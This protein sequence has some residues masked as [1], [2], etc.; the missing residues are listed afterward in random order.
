MRT[1]AVA[2]IAVHR[3]EGG[4]REFLVVLRSSARHGYWHLV[5]GG[6][7]EGET[8]AE[9]AC[10]ELEEETGLVG[11]LSFEPLPVSLSY[12]DGTDR[13]AVHAFAAEAPEEWEP[14]LDDEHV[15]HRWCSAEDAIALLRYEEPRQALR[16]TVRL[17]ASEVAT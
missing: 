12:H 9:A 3:R 8:P 6:V 14:V 17:L 1:L 10:R 13:I 2:L 15:E 5:S 4:E 7:E 11:T 16:E